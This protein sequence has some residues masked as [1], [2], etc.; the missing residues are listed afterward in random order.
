MQFLMLMAM[1]VS[2]M[3][4]ASKLCLKFFF[5]WSGSTRK[6]ES[7]ALKICIHV[8]RKV[9]KICENF[10]NSAPVRTDHP[11]ARLSQSTLLKNFFYLQY[12][13]LSSRVLVSFMTRS[14]EVQG[15]EETVHL[16][17]QLRTLPSSLPEAV[18]HRRCQK[19]PL[20]CHNSKV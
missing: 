12:R 5:G 13:F 4:R 14:G 1:A 3:K 9:P 11:L 7:I 17:V 20:D 8:Y 19:W 6:G 18:R 10:I 15:Q 2:T 16:V